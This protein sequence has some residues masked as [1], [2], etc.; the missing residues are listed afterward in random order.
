MR[1]ENKTVEFRLSSE[2]VDVCF[3]EGW[4]RLCLEFCRQTKVRGSLCQTTLHSELAT[5]EGEVTALF[6]FLGPNVGLVEFLA[7]L[8]VARKVEKNPWS[9]HVCHKA[10]TP[11]RQ[12]LEDS[13]DSRYCHRRGGQH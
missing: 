10:F 13:Q 11:S 4:V 8:I 7:N 5:M 12:L 6:D 1:R 3:A 9:C 2:T